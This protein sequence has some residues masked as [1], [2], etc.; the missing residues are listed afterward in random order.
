MVRTSND[1]LQKIVNKTMAHLLRQMYV[2][3]I[4]LEAVTIEKIVD[5]IFTEMIH[6]KMHQLE[7]EE[8]VKQDQTDGNNRLRFKKCSEV[9]DHEERWI[10]YAE[11]AQSLLNHEV[12][13]QG[14]VEACKILKYPEPSAMHRYYFETL[15]DMSC[16]IWYIVNRKEQSVLAILFT[17]LFVCVN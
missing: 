15:F 17:T 13:W 5:L 9:L 8:L 4:D 6:D 14:I 1:C 11:Q 12:M 16:F 2:D 10:T 3:E 7:K